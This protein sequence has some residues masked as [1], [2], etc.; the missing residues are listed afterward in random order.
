MDIVLDTNIIVQENFFRSKKFEVLVDYL[1]KTNSRIVLPQIVK[2]ES[3]SIYQKDI[4]SQLKKATRELEK[5]S[6]L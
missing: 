3:I 1:K 6:R 4:T 2:E 5:L